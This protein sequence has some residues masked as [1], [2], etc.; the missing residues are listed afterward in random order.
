MSVDTSPSSTAGP[1]RTRRA[2]AGSDR[3]PRRPDG[4]PA[5][6]APRQRRPALAALALLLVV[7]GA[8]VAGLV[9]VRM[10]SR[11]PVLAAATD[12]APGTLL[13]AADVTEVSVS[14]DGVALIPADLAGQVLDGTAYVEVPVTAGTLIDQSMLTRTPPIGEGRAIV[15]VPLSAAITPGAALRSGD[16]VQVVRTSGAAQGGAAGPVPLTEGL[17]VEITGGGSEDDLTAAATASV[18]LVVPES[19]AAEVVDAAGSDRAGLV[20]LDRGQSTDVD[21]RVLEGDGS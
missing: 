5:L 7:G 2:R 16:L 18:T 3:P 14:A 12:L 10:D 21:L 15:S 4:R 13:T 11:T 17:V 1:T 19:V 20:L 9:A 8:L 6:E